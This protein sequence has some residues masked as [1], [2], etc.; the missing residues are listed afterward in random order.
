MLGTV[1]VLWSAVEFNA[2][3]MENKYQRSIELLNKAVANEIATSLQYMY[4]H[5]HC[6]DKGYRPFA[7]Y[8]RWVSI[9]EM[10]HIERLSDRIMYLQG[11]VDMNQQFRVKQVTEVGDMLRLAAELESQT[12]ENYNAWSKETS[13]LQD[14]GTHKLFQDLVVEE[15]DH[16]DTFRTEAENMVEYGEEYLTLQS[17]DNIKHESKRSTDDSGVD[18]G[19]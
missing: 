8:F 18:D 1:I 2:L 7:K 3:K 12:I 17:M 19:Y 4:F 10:N 13:D 14:A 11:D 6:E 9:R 16:L 15:E 5:V